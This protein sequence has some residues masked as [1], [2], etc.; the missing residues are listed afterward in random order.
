MEKSYK[1]NLNSVVCDILERTAFLFPE[2]VDRADEVDF[3]DFQM[4]MATLSYSGNGEGDISFIVPVDLCLELAMNLLG[5]DIDEDDPAEKPQDAVK[6]ILNII[7]GQLLTRIFGETAVFNLTLPQA[8]NL[9]Q[10]TFKSIIE[11]EDYAL[12]MSDDYPIFT[13]MKAK[14]EVHEHEGPHS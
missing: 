2:P 5:E 12:A 7:A 9:D 11:K 14:E 4:V 3:G 13:I 1:E 8:K 10:E 6:E